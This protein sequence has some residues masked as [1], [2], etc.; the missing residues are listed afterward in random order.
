M[1][2]LSLHLPELTGLVPALRG[3]WRKVL[4]SLPFSPS[5]PHI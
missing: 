3:L 2:C 5:K 1:A 4:A